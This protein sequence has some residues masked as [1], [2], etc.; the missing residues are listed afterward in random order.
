[1]PQKRHVIYT[2]SKDLFIIY[3]VLLKGGALKEFTALVAVV[4]PIFEANIVT[5]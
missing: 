2:W 1:M 4:V 3:F 5:M